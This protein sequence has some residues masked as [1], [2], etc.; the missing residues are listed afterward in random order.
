MKSKLDSSG[1]KVYLFDPET[2]E[3]LGS[4]YLVYD[5]EFLSVIES[6]IKSIL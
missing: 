5:P 3:N 6:I 4:Q 1:E 2:D